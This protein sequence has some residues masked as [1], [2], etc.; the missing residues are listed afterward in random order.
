MTLPTVKAPTTEQLA[1]VAAELGFSFTDAELAAHLA[2]LGPSVDAY[3]LVDRMT[4]ELPTVTY[5]RTPGV[6]PSGEPSRTIS[7]SPACR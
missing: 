4:D 6:F 3:N 5:P 7:A 2:A 1:D